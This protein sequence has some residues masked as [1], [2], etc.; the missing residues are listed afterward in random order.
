MSYTQ[1]LQTG[2]CLRLEEVT[3]EL[4]NILA[5]FLHQSK[6]LCSCVI[7]LISG[8]LKFFSERDDVYIIQ[9]NVLG[10]LKLINSSSFSLLT[11]LDSL[12]LDNDL[13]ISVFQIS[14]CWSLYIPRYLYRIYFSLGKC[15]WTKGVFLQMEIG[16][17][18]KNIYFFF[19]TC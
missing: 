8:V 9:I 17:D 18:Q 5:L 6:V 7:L 16:K 10:F 15:T 11:I 14:C 2:V 3:E 19:Q 1:C 4:I 13:C 12:T